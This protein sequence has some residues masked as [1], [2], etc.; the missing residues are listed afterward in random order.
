MG[1]L[2]PPPYQDTPGS[3]AWNAWYKQINDLLAGV[4]TTIN[5]VDDVTI[6]GAQT[7][8]FFVYTDEAEWENVEVPTVV[9]ILG[10][11]TDDSVVFNTLDVETLTA[12][13]I[14][15]AT[16]LWTGNVDI[17]GTLTGPTQITATEIDIGAS[18]LS[19]LFAAIEHDHTASEVT[20]FVSTGDGQW[21]EVEHSH[22][23]S[24]I[25]D[26]SA[27]AWTLIDGGTP[28]VESDEILL[29]LS[30]EY[31][32]YKVVFWGIT[33]EAEA[34]SFLRITLAEAEVETTAGYR[35]Y[36]WGQDSNGSARTTNQSGYIPLTSYALD[37]DEPGA[38]AFGT[39]YLASVESGRG[40][41][42][43]G[44]TGWRMLDLDRVVNA[45]VMGF[46]NVDEDNADDRVNINAG[47]S[48]FAATGGWA[49][50]GSNNA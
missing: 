20:D 41:Q 35:A 45:T 28:V 1:Q 18:E 10:F 12:E 39:I 49:L 32:I 9:E 43:W 13:D 2:S 29:D 15:G 30:G 11:D 19:A 3:H 6:T 47:G 22:V 16:A 24:E 8:D 48:T 34:A 17:E 38:G 21:A 7:N 40:T 26:L 42:A 37:D 25:T 23:S 31:D 27:G 44:T 36:V 46:L 5:N 14:E 4:S 50:Y 33:L